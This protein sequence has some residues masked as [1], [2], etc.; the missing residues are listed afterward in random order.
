MLEKRKPNY[1]ICLAAIYLYLKV[2]PHLNEYILHINMLV[3]ILT[4]HKQCTGN[5]SRN[6]HRIE[7][8]MVKQMAMFQR[9]T[10]NYVL[11]IR[12][13]CKCSVQWHDYCPS[14][15]HWYHHVLKTSLILC[16]YCFK[17]RSQKYI[18]L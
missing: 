7:H 9:Q 1:N 10:P 6:M 4:R 17:Q 8:Q 12:R 14:I 11:K 15:Q 18:L 2:D 13:H 16:R 3:Q 5:L